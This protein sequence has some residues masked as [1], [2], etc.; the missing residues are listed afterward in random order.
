MTI[1]ENPRRSIL[2]TSD[3]IKIENR[4]GF[5]Y[6]NMERQNEKSKTIGTGKNQPETKKSPRNLT[7]TRILDALLGPTRRS[8]FF[9]G[10]FIMFIITMIWVSILFI[11]PAVLPANSVDLG[12]DGVVG[13][14]PLKEN[15]REEIRDQ[16]ESDFARSIYDFGDETCHQMNHRTL[17]I[18]GNQMPLCARDIGIY[19]GFVI[20]ALLVTFYVVE[21]R[22]WWILG[23]LI[24]IGADGLTQALTTYESNNPMR[25]LT[26]GLAG[27]MT[28]MVIGIIIYELY[29]GHKMKKEYELRLKSNEEGGAATLP[30]DQTK[31]ISG[32]SIKAS[33]KAKAPGTE[34]RSDNTK[35]DIAK[36]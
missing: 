17:F 23:A 3:G 28:T 34:Q 12:D 7:R 13:V 10:N 26:G 25:L 36:K 16:I 24:P 20:G 19:V 6:M 30:K 15:N 4:I 2:N 5:D 14:E 29:V 22:I 27:M 35:K 31:Q 9:Y 8:Y 1:I 33:S 21:L 18:N 11:I 32:S